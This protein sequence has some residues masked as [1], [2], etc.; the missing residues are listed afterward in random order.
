MKLNF[1]DCLNTFWVNIKA[2]QKKKLLIVAV[3][4]F[5][6]WHQTSFPGLEFFILSSFWF[7]SMCEG[8]EGAALPSSPSRFLRLQTGTRRFWGP[9]KSELTLTHLRTPTGEKPN[10]WRPHVCRW[11]PGSH[12]N[13]HRRNCSCVT[14]GKVFRWGSNLQ[15]EVWRS[16]FVF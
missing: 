7:E 5:S 16:C 11:S 15:A 12:H 6:P 8:G 1:H 10:V 9:E 13:Q 14:C 4:M 3:G 2:E